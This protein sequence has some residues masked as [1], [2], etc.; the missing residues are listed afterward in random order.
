MD[1]QFAVRVDGNSAVITKESKW[2]PG[3]DICKQ[4]HEHFKDAK[5][6]LMVHYNYRLYDAENALRDAYNLK[7]EDIVS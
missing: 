1:M 3:C 6:C 4:K 5:K 7:E 2:H